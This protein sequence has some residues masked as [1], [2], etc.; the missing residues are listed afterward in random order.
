M[1]VVNKPYGMLSVPGSRAATHDSALSRAKHLYPDITGSGLVH[2]L[3]METSGI[4]LVARNAPA[5]S[6]LCA[7]FRERTLEKVYEAVLDGEVSESEGEITLPLHPEG[8]GSLLQR[9]DWERGRESVTL[10]RVLERGPGW[11]RI[12]FRPITG[13]THQLR[14]H[15]SSPEGLGAPIR[16]DLLY[17]PAPQGR[18]QLHARSLKLRHPAT[19][20]VLMLECPTP[21]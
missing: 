18:L 2:R 3:D 21:F 9:V 8:R 14:V 15:A 17:H 20:D 5:Q 7:Q 13:R 1:L 16:G 6:V 12:E 19:G 4:L 10:F 11:T